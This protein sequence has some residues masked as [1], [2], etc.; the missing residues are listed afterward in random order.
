MDRRS[1][2]R[3]LNHRGNS[4][5]MEWEFFGG[6]PVERRTPFVDF[7]G[8]HHDRVGGSGMEQLGFRPVETGTHF[9][10][11]LGLLRDR[12]GGSGVEQSGFRAGSEI[13]VGSLMSGKLV[14]NGV[15]ESKKMDEELGS[16]ID[17]KLFEKWKGNISENAE[18]V[19]DLSLVSEFAGG[20]MLWDRVVARVRF[21]ALCKTRFGRDSATWRNWFLKPSQPVE[22]SKPSVPL[23][24]PLYKEITLMEL[25]KN[26][27]RVKQGR[28]AEINFVGPFGE[29]YKRIQ[30][31]GNSKKAQREAG[32]VEWT[33]AVKRVPAIVPSLTEL[34][35]AYL[36]EYSEGIVSLENVP[37]EIRHKLCRVACDYG[38]MNWEFM[39]LLAGGAPSEI[40]VPDCTWMTTE[41]FED[42]FC[43]CDTNSLKI[44]RL[45][46]LE[47]CMLDHALMSEVL[48]P[49]TFRSLVTLS[50]KGAVHLTDKG[51]ESLVKLAPSL[52]SLD[53]SQCP[54]LTSSGI[55]TLAVWYGKTLEKLYVDDCLAID[56]MAL[57]PALTGFLNLQVLSVAGS[58]SVC[59]DFV[60]HFVA[61]RGSFMKELV[62][63]SCSNLTDKAVEAIGSTC[64]SLVS[65]DI[66]NLCNITDLA[67]QHIANGS[68]RIEHLELSHNAFSDEA[69]AAFLEVS[70]HYLTELFI[71]DIRKV[72][73]A[74]A[75]SLAKFTRNLVSLDLSQCLHITENMLGQIVEC[76]TRL[77][78]LQLFGCSQ[79]TNVFLDGHSNPN[80]E[81]LGA[82]STSAQE[83][84]L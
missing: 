77:R 3:R 23:R 11:F 51:L 81:V 46:M 73:P 74:T 33:P 24:F 31:R 18:L 39:K 84:P 65:L 20:K 61:V 6:N 4:D 7:L 32:L 35:F 68:T 70:G 40:C 13:G 2:R 66:S 30:K 14:W 22:D 53:L 55:S 43:A 48:S 12:A 17:L 67:L 44:L 47:Q 29:A 21:E 58:S 49:G 71:K 38:K 19:T 64:S 5:S 59:D 16:A 57:L 82:S 78:L 76:C 75:V 42:M 72:G 37:V 60:C 83:S 25:V 1:R 63:A 26:V 54:L 62:F 41:Q 45:E 28:K 50:L 27:E 56:A 79:I 52:R 8:L 10:D 34:S 69:V 36:A 80:L 15:G 9:V